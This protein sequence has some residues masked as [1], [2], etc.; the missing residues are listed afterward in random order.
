MYNFLSSAVHTKMVTLSISKPLSKRRRYV[1]ARKVSTRPFERIATGNVTPVEVCTVLAQASNQTD[2]HLH[3][4]ITNNPT[5]KTPRQTTNH[6]NNP[7]KNQPTSQP[8]IHPLDL[9][10]NQPTIQPTTSPTDQQ[11]TQNQQRYRPNRP[12]VPTTTYPIT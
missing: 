9:Q 5:N 7:P 2:S 3:D 1:L 11:A 10:T 4:H 8:I 6:P 12:T